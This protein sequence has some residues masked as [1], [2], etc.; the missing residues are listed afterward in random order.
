MDDFELE[1]FF[2]TK[3]ASEYRSFRNMWIN[4]FS[5]QDN[6]DFAKKVREIFLILDKLDIPEEEKYIY[7][8]E[9]GNNIEYMGEYTEHLDSIIS[10]IISKS[11][12]IIIDN[13]M[14]YQNIKIRYINRNGP[15]DPLTSF[16]DYIKEVFDLL[17]N[18][19][20]NHRKNIL[21]KLFT[22]ISAYPRHY[23]KNMP[24]ETKKIIRDIKIR[25]LS[26][27]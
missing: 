23:W 19:S 3:D 18:V 2:Q 20:E 11:R 1:D 5:D 4:G 14:T 17:D 10:N 13:I 21:P 16:N 22:H 27:Y 25:E 12:N 8:T 26:L 24:Q 7:I 9:K 6:S 15:F